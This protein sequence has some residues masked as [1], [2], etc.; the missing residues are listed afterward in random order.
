M[1]MK[2]VFTAMLFLFFAA[3]GFAQEKE[4]QL[5]THILDISEGLPAGDVTIK[6][7]KMNIDS[8]EW[9][10]VSEK[11]TGE[12]GRINDF[13]PSNNDNAG[14]Y[15]FT[16]YVADYFKSKN[17]ESFYP[18]VEV[19]FEIKGD[20]HYHVPITLSAFGYST[21]RGS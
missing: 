9:E 6:L 20:K 10:L 17:R 8:K 14:T 11:K 19:A 18:F 13:L 21:Y 12:D 15:R 4:Y 16:F 5:S 1:M 2:R 3:T 7:E